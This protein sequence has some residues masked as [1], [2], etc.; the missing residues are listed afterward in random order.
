MRAWTDDHPLASLGFG[1][2]HYAGQCLKVRAT[3]EQLGAVL[4][5]HCE[6]DGISSG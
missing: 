2:E 6:D 3:S 4:A 5:R 1:K